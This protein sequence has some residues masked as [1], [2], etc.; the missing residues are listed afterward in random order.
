MTKANKDH[1][2]IDEAIAVKGCPPNPDDIVKALHRAGIPADEAL[3]RNIDLLPAFFMERYK[4][5][6]EYDPSLFQVK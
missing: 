4:E 3:F 6:P 2:N 5:K 1:P